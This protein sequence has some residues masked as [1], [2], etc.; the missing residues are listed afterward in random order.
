LHVCARSGAVYIHDKILV[1]LFYYYLCQK[2]IHFVI[3]KKRF[4]LYIWYFWKNLTFNYT[5]NYK[6][7]IYLQINLHIACYTLSF[8]NTVQ[9][10]VAPGDGGKGLNIVLGTRNLHF[11]GSLGSASSGIRHSLLNQFS[12][13]AISPHIFSSLKTL[14]TKKSFS[15]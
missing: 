1:Y 3:F 2:K 13:G 15:V 12:F 14:S 10:D 8:D 6:F 4:A 7:F 11:L 9:E 5:H